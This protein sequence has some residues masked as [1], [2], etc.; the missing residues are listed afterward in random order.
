M[1][2]IVS[3]D[4]PAATRVCRGITLNAEYVDWGVDLY[5]PK[6]WCKLAC[7]SL[8]HAHLERLLQKQAINEFETIKPHMIVQTHARNKLVDVSACVS[9]QVCAGRSNAASLKAFMTAPPA[10]LESGLGNPDKPQ[11]MRRLMLEAVGS[12]LVRTSADVQRYCYCTLV[13]ALKPNFQAV[14]G[15]AINSLKWLSENGHLEWDRTSEVRMYD[16]RS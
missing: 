10:A 13:A 6:M 8:Q 3:N 1:V 9:M 15:P 11:G 4:A 16:T 12:G 5:M 14:A 2:S 7:V